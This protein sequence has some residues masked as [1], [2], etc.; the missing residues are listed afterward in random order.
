MLDRVGE[1]AGG[2]GWSETARVAS[3]EPAAAIATGRGSATARMGLARAAGVL[4]SAARSV[5][6]GGE[7]GRAALREAATGLGQELTGLAARDPGGLGELLRAAF[8]E[9]AEGPAGRALAARLAAGDALMPA[10]ID[11][12][13]AGTLP[14][15]ALGAYVSE[16]AG[17]ILLDRGLLGEPA[18]LR[19]VLAEELGHHLDRLLGPGDAA[20]D[21]GAVFARL[22][23][24][25]RLSPSE[26]ARLRAEDDRGRLADGRVV[27][28]RQEPSADGSGRVG[29]GSGGDGY[30]SSGT[31]GERD[32]TTRGGATV[33]GGS[34]GFSG[35]GYG[36]SGTPGERD[37]STRGGA[38][39]GGGRGSDDDE[40]TAAGRRGGATGGSRGTSPASGGGAADPSRGPAFERSGRG[41]SPSG[42]DFGALGGVGGGARPDPA[43]AAMVERAAAAVSEALGWGGDL[44][45]EAVRGVAAGVGLG[46]AVVRGEPGAVLE[47]IEAVAAAAAGLPRAAAGMGEVVARAVERIETRADPTVHDARGLPT[48]AEWGRRVASWAGLP[49]EAG[50]ATVQRG[51]ELARSI[52]AA[53]TPLARELARGVA[54]GAATGAFADRSLELALELDPRAAVEAFGGG[55]G[56]LG[57][58]LAGQGLRA[59]ERALGAIAEGSLGGLDRTGALTAMAREMRPEHDLN[60]WSPDAGRAAGEAAGRAAFAEALVAAHRPGLQGAERDRAVEEVDR[61]LG[62]KA[63]WS[64]L[65]RLDA[66]GWEAQKAALGRLAT[67]PAGVLADHKAETAREGDEAQGAKTGRGDGGERA[68]GAGG[69]REPEGVTGEGDRSDGAEDWSRGGVE[70]GGTG[71]VERPATARTTLTFGPEV[72]TL[73]P[74]PAATPGRVV[75]SP[76]GLAALN[77][78]YGNPRGTGLGDGV[79]GLG[80]L[81]LGV[82]NLAAGA[83]G[84]IVTPS[85]GRLDYER[86]TMFS[87]DLRVRG[88]GDTPGATLERRVEGRWG[89][90]SRWEGIGV[91]LERDGD[92]N[93]VID[94]ATLDALTEEERA[95]IEGAPG[96]SAAPVFSFPNHTGRA[97][98]ETLADLPLDTGSPA[99]APPHWSDGLLADPVPETE[100]PGVVTMDPNNPRAVRAQQQAAD[101]MREAFPDSVVVEE[102]RFPP[103]DGFEQGDID[104]IVSG[105]P[106]EVTS[107]GGGKKVKQLPK[108]ENAT[109]EP[110]IVYAPDI[111]GTVERNLTRDGYTVVR[112]LDALEAAVRK[113]MKTDE[114]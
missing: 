31:P 82:G 26:L 88:S 44:L 30:G 105:V 35:D 114:G 22:L 41:G 60:G 69:R 27:E 56:R 2:A 16:G 58:A 93:L 47:V 52:P 107:G 100:G 103:M 42:F 33:G 108:I 112:D 97:P 72:P 39:V 3:K 95:L 64:A 5:E 73:D 6:G 84:L 94:R 78:A 90:G 65:E 71:R 59:R 40:G 29:G 77:A 11:W 111:G 53:R 79:R 19:S 62:H 46:R 101:R 68:R 70:D 51:I 61:V 110:P 109:G 43:V 106:V 89:L 55:G 92:W 8:G 37:G 1:G 91:P 86:T 83:V 13:G 87:E 17:T 96:S 14:P 49:V 15:G 80:R 48:A 74:G 75:F 63:G 28:L 9:K 12:A 18:R 50:L 99:P 4:A 21:E 113:R 104:I 81:G 57:R 66:M 102:T 85:F 24:G 76:A 34:G 32:G 10:R 23:G 7:A 36:R 45:G 38:T 98:D 54:S 67:D 20:G 25:E